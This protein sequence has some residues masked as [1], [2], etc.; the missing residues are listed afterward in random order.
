MCNSKAVKGELYTCT[1]EGTGKHAYIIKS[2]RQAGKMYGE[3]K[4]KMWVLY[5]FIY[6]GGV[7]FI[8][9]C[10]YIYTTQQASKMSGDTRTSPGSPPK[11][12]NGQ[13]Q[14]GAPFGEVGYEQNNGNNEQKKD[15]EELI[16]WATLNQH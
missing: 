6:G 2:S 9:M 1:N 5:I 7:V 15:R 13:K 10:I 14:M 4:R 3:T 8:Y 11:E 12:I 16:S